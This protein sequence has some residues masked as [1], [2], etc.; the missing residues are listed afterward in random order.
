MHDKELTLA[1]DI[2][3][4]DDEP[5]VRLPG[6]VKVADFWTFSNREKD[7]IDA[8]RDQ[9]D[10]YLAD[11]ASKRPFSL[12]VFGAPGSGKSRTVRS[13]RSAVQGSERGLLRELA[14]INLTQ[15]ASVPDLATSLA[16]ALRSDPG[17]DAENR[18]PL[19]LFDEFDTAFHGA[20]WGWLSWFLAVMQDG[21]FLH[22]GSWV[23][24]KRSV[25]A[26]AGG[27]AERYED[28]G[29]SNDASFVSAKGP[30]F[31]SRLTAYLDIPGVNAKP[32]RSLRRAVVL[33]AMRT[34]RKLLFDRALAKQLCG[35]GRYRFGARSMES[36]IDMMRPSDKRELGLQCLPKPVLRLMHVDRGPLDRHNMGGGLGFSGSVED[37]KQA[38]Q[39]AK[40]WKEVASD[41]LEDGAL[42]IYGGRAS[43]T[44][45]A[46]L[47][48]V[49]EG[50]PLGL[51]NPDDKEDPQ[52]TWIE[53][54]RDESRKLAGDEP[55][56]KYAEIHVT[57]GSWAEDATRANSKLPA[58]A[59]FARRHQMSL[60][61]VARFAIGG[62]LNPRRSRFPGIAEEVMLALAMKQP[63]YI[64]GC[65]GDKEPVGAARWVGTLLGLGDCWM[66]EPD[67]FSNEVYDEGV[68][69]ANAR[70]FR[71]PPLVDLPATR[72]ELVDYFGRHAL[73]GPNW[74]DN[75][76]TQ[77]QNRE[78]FRETRPKRITELVREG[79]VRRF[80]SGA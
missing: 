8:V 54:F 64:S 19:I 1:C 65:L 17:G 44:L 50:L 51:R 30:D 42:I 76:L 66:G 71:P 18:A 48:D 53:M 79:L 5:D 49:I 77:E 15:I 57:T 55:W 33:H 32:H 56:P 47:E 62:K 41:L 74:P 36:L 78:L 45:S 63:V 24:L 27:T 12:A 22:A 38:D 4:K 26:F 73:G 9:M 21:K 60:S 46:V 2:V 31:K 80:G 75:G 40:V 69:K 28:F 11:K 67:G 52:E 35:V 14:E 25:L 68:L 3:M 72:A 43:R 70:F 61:C 7:Q 13:L 34:K 37:A 59:L 6:V 29:R 10:T 58:L 39:G 20:Q 16:N 23:P